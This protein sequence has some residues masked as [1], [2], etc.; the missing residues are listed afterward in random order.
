MSKSHDVH[1]VLYL[2]EKC[3]TTKEEQDFVCHMKTGM[4]YRLVF[5]K[6][7]INYHDLTRFHLLY[8]ALNFLFLSTTLPSHRH[9]FCSCLNV[10]G[11]G[12]VERNRK[13]KA[14]TNEILIRSC[15]ILIWTF[16]KY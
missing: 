13:F 3:A 2:M 8:I 7:W 4:N 6:V 9:L 11:E 16:S 1:S 10:L 5:W 12:K 15:Y 14:T